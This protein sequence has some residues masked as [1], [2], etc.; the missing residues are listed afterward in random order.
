[1]IIM[2]QRT[3]NCYRLNDSLLNKLIEEFGK[4]KRKRT[5]V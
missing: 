2:I 1:M 3:A 5:Q 4:I